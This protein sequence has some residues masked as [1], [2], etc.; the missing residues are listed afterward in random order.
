[1]N[2]LCW[3]L[4]GIPRDRTIRVFELSTPTSVNLLNIMYCVLLFIYFME[5]SP[6]A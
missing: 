1:M 5:P 4:L 6:A 2:E 3:N